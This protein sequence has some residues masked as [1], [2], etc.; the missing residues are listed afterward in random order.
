M[1]MPIVCE[2]NIREFVYMKAY[3]SW[4]KTTEFCMRVR[5]IFRGGKLQVL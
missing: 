3:I 1:R 2:V 5:P 4:G